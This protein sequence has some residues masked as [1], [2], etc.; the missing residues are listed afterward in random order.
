ME[1]ESLTKV[2]KNLYRYTELHGAQRGEPYNWNS[3][4]IH[5]PEHGVLALVDPLD[6]RTAVLSDIESIGHPT[7]ILLTCEIRLR[8]SLT[9]RDRWDC[10][11]WANQIERDLYDIELDGTFTHG[12]LLWDSVS[13]TYI[14]DAYYPET[15]LLIHGEPTVLFIGDIIS[16]AR[17]DQGVPVEQLGIIHP[18]GIP[19][20]QA[21]RSGLR[22]LLDLDFNV[23]CFGHGDPVTLD[24][25]SKLRAYL[26]D[27]VIWSELEESK[28]SYSAG[29]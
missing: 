12:D 7:H 23:I 5:F 20:T 29:K 11:I 19:D 17:Q 21:C 18:V 28:Q 24:A 4:V 25:K 13:C 10:Q 27:D 15:A 2:T 22:R 1:F 16:G 9:F 8:S 26:E 6:A 14:P 3:Y